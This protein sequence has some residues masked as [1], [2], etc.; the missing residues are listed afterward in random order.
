MHYR[1]VSKIGAV[2]F[3]GVV[4]F[5]LLFHA[6]FGGVAEDKEARGSIETN[7]VIESSP[8]PPAPA[9]EPEIDNVSFDHH[10]STAPPQ[11]NGGE[12]SHGGLQRRA[13]SPP[14][15]G[16]CSGRGCGER[17]RILRRRR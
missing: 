15:R 17:R 7:S 2:L 6:I 4:P 8:V 1:N 14:S 16:N 5:A 9:L 3:I 13:F 12:G 11:A 10:P